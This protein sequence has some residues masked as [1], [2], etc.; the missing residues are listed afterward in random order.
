MYDYDMITSQ[1]ASQLSNIMAALGGLFFF[2]M[3][4][5]IAIVV[6][7]IVALCKFYKKAGKNGW[8][9]IVPFYSSW[10]LVEIAG[11]N[12]WWFLLL[13]S[14]TISSMLLGNDSK[15]SGAVT[16]VT[17]FGFFVCNYNISKRLHKD[18]GFAVLLTIFPVI[19]YPIIAFNK[20]YVYDGNVEVSKN[21]PFN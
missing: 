5:I 1:N 19:M 17:L 6:L 16:L 21:G 12:W 10:V 4:I 13:I 11:L 18:T 9:A 8:E 20:D 14:G 2:V 15:I 7:L 3:I